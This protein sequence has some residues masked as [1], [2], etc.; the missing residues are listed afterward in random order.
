MHELSYMV[1]LVDNALDEID[2]ES[3]RMSDG[4]IL[5]MVVSVGEMTGV[6]PEY[7]HKYYP[8]TVKGTILEGSELEVR[9]VE[10]AVECAGCKQIYR[11]T[12]EN[13]Y[14]CPSCGNHNGRIVAGRDVVLERLEV[15]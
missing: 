1:R 3:G 4:C 9:T 14:A 8:Q 13:G 2:A 15:V 11:P 10:A 12:R 6:L 7:L 5:K